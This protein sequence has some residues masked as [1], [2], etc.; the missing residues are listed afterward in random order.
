MFNA[1]PV[2]V[3]GFRLCPISFLW[4]RSCFECRY[5]SNGISE[6][7]RKAPGQF[8]GEW[9]LRE[10]SFKRAGQCQSFPTSAF[11]GL[12]GI[13]LN[14]SRSIPLLW[15]GSVLLIFLYLRPSFNPPLPSS[16]RDRSF[17]V[18]TIPRIHVSLHMLCLLHASKLHDAY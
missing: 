13:F 8:V 5:C 11:H 16:S 4:T 10:T 18:H 6:C 1:Q 15:F 2:C 17:C 3:C 9:S 12:L 7:W 14:C